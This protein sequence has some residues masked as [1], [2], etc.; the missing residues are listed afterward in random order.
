MPASSIA[1]ILRSLATSL[2]I[3]SPPAAEAADATTTG[4]ISPSAFD[5]NRSIKELMAAAE[6]FLV[7]G[8]GTLPPNVRD[9]PNNHSYN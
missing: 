5:R 6:P 7:D 2:D 1:L 9:I 4:G 3:V 8:L